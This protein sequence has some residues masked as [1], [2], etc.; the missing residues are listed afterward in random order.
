ME[1]S[2]KQGRLLECGLAECARWP[3]RPVPGDAVHPEGPAVTRTFGD[4]A[5]RGKYRKERD[6]WKGAGLTEPAQTGQHSDLSQSPSEHEGE[7]HMANSEQSHPEKFILQHFHSM[8][9][10][11][12]QEQVEGIADLMRKVGSR[13]FTRGAESS[14]T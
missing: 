2:V 14:R 6:K 12:D 4:V 9:H 1:T 7:E 8:F 11:E 3:P 10:S 13:D 5:N